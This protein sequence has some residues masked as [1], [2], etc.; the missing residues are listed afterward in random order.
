MSQAFPSVVDVTQTD[1]GETRPIRVML[2]DD[3][4][5][6]RN[7]V[8]M[9]LGADPGLMVV[10]EASDGRDVIGAVHAHHPDVV[11]MDL[12]MPG[13]N[14]IVVTARLQREVNPPRVIALTSVDLDSYVFEAL[15]AGAAGFLLKDD[16]PEQIRAGVRTVHRG[17][18]VLSPR[19]TTYV[20]R[21]FVGDGHREETERAITL[22]ALLT[23]RETEVVGLVHE[24]LSNDQIARRLGCSAATVKTHLS[25]A[26]AKLDVPS[27][28]QIALLV[29]RA[30]R[31]A[32]PMT[33]SAVG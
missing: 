17:D 20:I 29:E 24:G 1:A 32:T 15:E 22:L 26:M 9:I 31:V 30:A 27:R 28:V 5:M 10:A 19:A 14:G 12:H 21:R 25:H 18:S 23:E 13:M 3:D 7:G 4:A 6:A 8:R 33:A 2:V 11:L 16:P